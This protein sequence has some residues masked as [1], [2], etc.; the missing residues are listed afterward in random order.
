MWYVCLLA[1]VHS[2]RRLFGDYFPVDPVYEDVWFCWAIRVQDKR[3]P[4]QIEISRR[5]CKYSATIE[6]CFAENYLEKCQS[7]LDICIARK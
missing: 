5:K 7:Y 3:F 2:L 6:L 1:I 4:E